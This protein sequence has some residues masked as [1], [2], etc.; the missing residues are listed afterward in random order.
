MALALL[1]P[2]GYA[3]VAGWVQERVWDMPLLLRVLE[4]APVFVLLVLRRWRPR[5]AQRSVAGSAPPQ[6]ESDST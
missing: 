5:V 1:V 4:Y 6:R 2:L 3:P